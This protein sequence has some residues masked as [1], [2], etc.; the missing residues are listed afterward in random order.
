MWRSPSVRRGNKG[1]GDRHVCQTF[2]E[3][4][5]IFLV[6]RCENKFL[7]LRERFPESH[8]RRRLHEFAWLKIRCFRALSPFYQ[9]ILA[10]WARSHGRWLRGCFAKLMPVFAAG[11]GMVFALRLEDATSRRASLPNVTGRS[12]MKAFSLSAALALWA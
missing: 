4:R 6:S 3:T 11:Q 8:G 2:R 5:R 7:R 10:R 1:D 9:T 12:D